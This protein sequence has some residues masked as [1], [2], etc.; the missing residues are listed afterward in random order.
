MKIFNSV[1]QMKLATI[2]AGQYVETFGYYTKGDA[3]AARYLVVAS[4]TADGY[5]DHTLANGT[6]A[7]LQVGGETNVKQ[8]GA[9]GDGVTDDTVAVQATLDV[10]GD[11]QSGSTGGYAAIAAS[12]ARVVVPDGEYLI[13][14]TLECP[15]NITMVGTSWGTKFKFDPVLADS[16]FMVNKP[17]TTGTSFQKSGISLRFEN[18]SVYPAL[19]GSVV[20]GRNGGDLD[21][22]NSNSRHCFN[23]ENTQAVSLDKVLITSFHYGTGVRFSTNYITFA[24]YNMITNCQVRDCLLGI[25]PTSA[26]QIIGTNI[27]HGTRYPELA[28]MPLHTYAVDVTEFS[29]VAMSG[30]SIECYASTALIGDSGR[31]NVF[32]GVYTE[33]Y[34]ATP[35]QID[36]T[37]QSVSASCPSVGP[38][39]YGFNFNHDMQE[40]VAR[41]G[42]SNFN[43]G[44]NYTF[45]DC[46]ELEIEHAPSRQ[47]PSFREGLPDAGHYPAG[48]PLSVSTDSFID[49]TSLALGRAA[50][51]ASTNNQLSYNFKIRDGAKA[52]SNVWVTVLVKVEGG[53]DDFLIRMTAP[54]NAHFKKIMTYQNGWELWGTYLTTVGAEQFTFITTQNA[55]STDAAR[56]V[57]VTGLRAYVN[58]FKPIP[59]TYRFPERRDTV[60]TT[61]DWL[62]GDT[63]YHSQPVAGGAMG[64]VC[65]TSGTPGTWKTFGVIG[66]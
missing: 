58:G 61:G 12:G 17:Y 37:A 54:Q 19:T 4:Q 51:T 28:R 6:V 23:I 42:T 21:E 5:G 11:T 56:I 18:F 60:P 38:L 52:A 33:A 9:T 47:S 35:A 25:R 40:N 57:K 13:T 50:G 15:N 1:A 20:V 30:G 29:G 59:A 53:E 16:D 65:T 64:W 45:G 66:A 2:K 24:Y 14:A 39:T 22:V 49:K 43:F 10:V 41:T 27:S 44:S 36:Q 3:G 55:G 26:N 63:V 34:S 31:G 62:Q 7:V 32:S 48:G 46:T 8:F